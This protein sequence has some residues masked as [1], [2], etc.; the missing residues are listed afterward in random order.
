MGAPGTCRIYY[1][2][3]SYP[4]NY[5]S[6]PIS[7]W[8]EQNYNVIIETFMG[9]GNRNTIFSNI[10]PGAFRELYN[11]LGT[12]KFI[13]STYSSSNTL[14]L[15]PQSSYG[16][17]SLREKRVVAV[18]SASDNFITPNYFNVKLETIRLDI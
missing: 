10:V 17:S 7:R 6:V 18:K 14:I 2:C 15:E 12:P 9:S 1:S 11:I 8:D 3:N 4:T 5:V 16:I 13:D